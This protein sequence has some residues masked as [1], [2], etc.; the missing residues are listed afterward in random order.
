M[1]IVIANTNTW[2]KKVHFVRQS[3][4]W[5]QLG[6]SPVTVSKMLR[7]LEKLG[8][9]RRERS[10]AADRRQ[11]YVELTRK[12]RGLRKVNRGH[13][14]SSSSR[15]FSSSARTTTLM[16]IVYLDLVEGDSATRRRFT[17][18]VRSLDASGGKTAAR[19]VP[20]S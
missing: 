3:D 4:I 7:A 16:F 20:M 12:A 15:F 19:P 18:V 9:V 17:I 13:T 14:A 2:L 10:I 1:L 8:L 6:V 11:V 5:R